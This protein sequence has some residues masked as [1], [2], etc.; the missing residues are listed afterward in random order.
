MSLFRLAL[1]ACIMGLGA[2]VCTAK[3]LDKESAKSRSLR[4][5]KGLR[6]AF[7]G[8]PQVDNET[9]LSYARNS[10]YRELRQRDDLDLVVVLG[11]LVNDKVSLLGP[12]K[13]S[14][15]SLECPWF[16]VPG[17]HDRDVYEDSPRDL[18]SF[19]KVLGY[20]DTSFVVRDVRFVL[21]NNVRLKDRQGYEGGFVQS[22]K[23]WLDSLLAGCDGRDRIVLATHIPVSH[24]KG[25]DSL[26]QCFARFPNAL[27]VS[28]HTHIVARHDIVLSDGVSVEEI[29]AGAACGSWWR[30]GKDESGIPC[31]LQNCGAPRG[32]FVADF[33]RNG[34]ELDYVP[35]GVGKDRYSLRLLDDGKL[36]LNVFGGKRGA[37]VKARIAG[38]WHEM[39]PSKSPAHEVQEIIELNKNTSREYRRAHRDEFIPLRRLASPHVWELQTGGED[40]KSG[41]VKVRYR[42]N[43]MKLSADFR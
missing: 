1:C 6:V 37:S 13:A 29:V 33:R 24:M 28:G 22:Q 12:S 4:P 43:A 10:I 14:L 21:M 42:D 7:V 16:C 40:V 20:V 27:F 36:V 8:D 26:K 3:D 11:D 39:S 41:K 34:Y 18:V 5:Y 19:R 15:D 30:G 2:L 23:E 35:V 9:E 38:K 31:A 25:L 32:Y 17:N